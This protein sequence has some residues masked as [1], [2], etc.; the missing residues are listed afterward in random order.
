MCEVQEKSARKPQASKLSS[1]AN[2]DITTAHD[3]M[4]SV[5]NALGTGSRGLFGENMMDE[6]R[7]LQH[8][9]SRPG[10]SPSLVHA[11]ARKY[12]ERL[13]PGVVWE[14]SEQ[15]I[16]DKQ[17]VKLLLDPMSQILVT[18]G[19]SQGLSLA[20]SAMAG[21]GDEVILIEPA[22]DI[23]TG[24]V[25][26]VGA[27]P[28]YVALKCRQANGNAETSADFVLD[29]DSLSSVMNSKTRL[30]VL[31]TPHNPTGKVF[32][33]AELQGI[34]K[35][36]DEFPHVAVI[37]DEVYEHMTYN[38]DLPHVPFASLSPSTFERTISMYVTIAVLFLVFLPFIGLFREKW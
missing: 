13:K 35:V 1:D 8:Q 27:T 18:V 31:N 32:S 30:L 11:I 6:K 36:L 3:V 14:N 24:A 21:P 34:A 23:Y 38:A 17:Q 7:S 10:G 5:H 33:R 16:D 12:S 25:L 37:S 26:Q 20:I 29:L 22:F 4:D 19:A 2:I 9:Y 28:R 15:H